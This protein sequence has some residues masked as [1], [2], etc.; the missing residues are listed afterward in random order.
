MS[1]AGTGIDLDAFVNFINNFREGTQHHCTQTRP[2]RRCPTPGCEISPSEDEAELPS[3]DP[4]LVHL[5]SHQSGS[6]SLRPRD[7]SCAPRA[8]QTEAQT[9]NKDRI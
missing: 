5:L 8:L 6:A 9:R 2:P 7:L 4:G 1:Q 3:S